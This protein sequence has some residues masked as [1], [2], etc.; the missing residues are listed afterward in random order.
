M[1]ATVSEY[2]KK[3]YTRVLIPDAESGTFTAQVLEFPG[4]VAQ[5]NNPAEAYERLEAAAESWI[6]A[7]LEMHQEIPQPANDAQFGGKYALRLPRSLHRQA[8]QLAELDGTSLNQFIV[9]TL[10]E[11]VGA[12]NVYR[13]LHLSL[14][15]GTATLSTRSKSWKADIASGKTAITA[16]S[17]QLH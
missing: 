7:A 14:I 3:P 6:E 15:A 5:G 1:N 2:L 8:A 17:E 4:C 11:K 13:R 9:T 16:A 12:V 10:A